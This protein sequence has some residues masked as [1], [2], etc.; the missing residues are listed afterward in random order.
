LENSSSGLEVSASDRSEKYNL[1]YVFSND[2]FYAYYI[3]ADGTA[4]AT[5]NRMGGEKL[6]VPLI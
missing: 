1:K 4:F 3:S 5:G 6:N 2:K